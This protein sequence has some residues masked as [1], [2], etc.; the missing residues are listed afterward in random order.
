MASCQMHKRSGDGVDCVLT[1]RKAPQLCA[2]RTVRPVISARPSLSIQTPR[3]LGLGCLICRDEALLVMNCRTRMA[4]ALVATLPDALRA[5]QLAP[6]PDTS[7][8]AGCGS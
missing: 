1:T 6:G 5:T 4:A 8:S 7:G 3:M 2:S